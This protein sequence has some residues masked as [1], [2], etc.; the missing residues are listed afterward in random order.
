MS[1]GWGEIFYIALI[2]CRS[3]EKYPTKRGFLSALISRIPITPKACRESD[4]RS[5]WNQG[6]SLG[7]N[8][9][10]VMHGINPKENTRDRVMPYAG[11]DSI[12]DCVVISCQSFGLDKKRTKRSLRSFFGDPYGGIEKVSSLRSETFGSFTCRRRRHFALQK[13]ETFR[14]FVSN[15]TESATKKHT[16]DVGVFF[17]W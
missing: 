3:G 11:G 14:G 13:R 7:W 6:V 10:E 1:I 12:H 2:W 17:C 9:H 8:H 4:R 16:D 15:R 5:V